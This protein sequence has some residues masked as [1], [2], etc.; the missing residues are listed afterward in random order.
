MEVHPVS[1][2]QRALKK[3]RGGPALRA[4][5]QAVAGDK[6]DFSDVAGAAKLDAIREKMK[7]GFYASECVA[8]DVSDKLAK[9]FDRL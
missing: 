3:G 8:D 6:V 5:P 7:A 1:S 9:L 2:V 4:R